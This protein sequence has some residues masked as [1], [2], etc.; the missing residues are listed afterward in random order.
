MDDISNEQFQA[1]LDEISECFVTRD[2]AVWRGKVIYPFSLITSAGP[3][4]LRNDDELRRNFEMY[5]FVCDQLNIDKVFRVP[6]SLE[7]CDD[8]TWIGTYVTH[9][10]SGAQRAARPFTSS[11]LMSVTPSGI[12]MTAILNARGTHEWIPQ[13]D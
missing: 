13:R 12:K 6:K 4:T 2:F 11:V 7:N 3:V 5:L 9:L 8:G 1:F 10:M